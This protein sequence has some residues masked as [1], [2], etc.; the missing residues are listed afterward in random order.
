MYSRTYYKKKEN[1]IVRACL[2]NE[3][4]FAVWHEAEEVFK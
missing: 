3:E 1:N 2:K 4:W